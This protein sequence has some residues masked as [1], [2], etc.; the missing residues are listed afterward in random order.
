MKV[1]YT[2]RHR[3]GG[4]TL[5]DGTQ[6]PYGEPV[7]VDDRYAGRL[8]TQQP[9]NFERVGDATPSKQEWLGRADAHGVDVSETATIKSIETAIAKHFAGDEVP[10]QPVA[11]Q[12]QEPAGPAVTADEQKEST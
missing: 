2:G 3:D 6:C 7:E 5:T 8:L 4:V 9:Q 10:E 11:Q 12:Q 1:K